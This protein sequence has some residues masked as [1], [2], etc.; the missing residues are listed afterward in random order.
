MHEIFYP[1]IYKSTSSFQE[2]YSAVINPEKNTRHMSSSA[3]ARSPSTSLLMEASTS[4]S[5]LFSEMSKLNI[6]KDTG[7][8]IGDNDG[9]SSNMEDIYEVNED[10][11]H[12]QDA[13]EGVLTDAS[14]SKRD[15]SDMEDIYEVKMPGKL[16]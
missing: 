5:S 9:Y 14:K 12:I 6:A 8:D 11:S 1:Y 15:S 10:E 16:C 4:N 3:S 2:L 7:T 13:S